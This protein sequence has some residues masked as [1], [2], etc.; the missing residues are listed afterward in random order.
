MDPASRLEDL[1]RLQR[2]MKE[3]IGR[4]LGL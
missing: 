4:D 1:G 3:I 2:V